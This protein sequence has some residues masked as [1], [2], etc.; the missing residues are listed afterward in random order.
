MEA[1]IR[2]TDLVD[3][4][5]R[6]MYP[7]DWPIMTDRKRRRKREVKTAPVCTQSDVNRGNRIRIFDESERAA[8][9]WIFWLASL[10]VRLTPPRPLPMDSDEQAGIELAE[11]DIMRCNGSA[12]RMLQG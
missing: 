11:L 3:C 4:S 7:N 10:L 1:G 9:T 6:R 2:T 12:R 5:E 8:L